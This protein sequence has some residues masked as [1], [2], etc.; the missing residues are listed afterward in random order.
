MDKLLA[1]F[2]AIT[3]FTETRNFSFGVRFCHVTVLAVCCAMDLCCKDFEGRR[4][5]DTG[6]MASLSC[7]GLSGVRDRPSESVKLFSR[8]I[9]VE[10]DVQCAEGGNI[11]WTLVQSA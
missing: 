10:G 8:G 7:S 6:E 9:V 5:A 3:L 1:R 2:K 4:R 11:Y